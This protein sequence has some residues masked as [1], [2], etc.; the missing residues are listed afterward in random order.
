MTFEQNI[1][2]IAYSELQMLPNHPVILRGFSPRL[3]CES[4]DALLHHLGDPEV[5]GYGKS[6]EDWQGMA[7][8]ELGAA[9]RLGQLDMNVVDFPIGA[10]LDPT[11]VLCVPEPMERGNLLLLDSDWLVYR[12][13]LVITQVGTK[14]EMHVDA[15]GLGGWM[16]LF[17]G[18]KRWQCW[19]AAQAPLFY[20]LVAGRYY[21][22]WSGHP[23]PDT[24]T[25]AALVGLPQWRGEIGPG[26][27]FWFPEG[28]LHR[29]ETDADSFGYGGSTLHAV[30]AEQAV[31]SWLWERRLG[32]SETADLAE[33]IQRAASHAPE[34]VD[35]ADLA[36]QAAVANAAI[37][38]TLQSGASAT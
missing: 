31:Q 12:K 17:A 28:W 5:Q 15:C 27:V 32:Y 10:D 33:L 25:A 36:Q 3:K 23:H 22:A 29:V 8:N 26:D 4:L 7:S 38:Q 11:D 16:Y 9:Y 2:I 14:T 21:D 34:L 19:N 13:S 30:R 37:T 20:D 6:G 18:H 24:E 35:L 1:P